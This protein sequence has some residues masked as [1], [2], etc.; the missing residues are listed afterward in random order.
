MNRES[1]RQSNVEPNEEFH[2]ANE[3]NIVM[4][5]LTWLPNRRAYAVRLNGQIIG[6]VCCKLPL[7]FRTPVEFC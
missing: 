3:E 1:Q 7:P 2:R 5:K 4:I 6:V